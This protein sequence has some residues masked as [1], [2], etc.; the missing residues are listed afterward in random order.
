[1]WHPSFCAISLAARRGALLTVALL[2]LPLISSIRAAESGKPALVVAGANETEGL[3]VSTNATAF[4]RSIQIINTTK[5][6]VD[7]TVDVSDLI[8]PDSKQVLTSWKLDGKPGPSATTQVKGLGNAHLDI[9]TNLSGAGVYQSTISLTYNGN[10][11][12]GL[13]DP[14]GVDRNSRVRRFETG[15]FSTRRKASCQNKCRLPAA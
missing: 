13:N 11:Y 9:T 3:A 10:R 1:M 2:F 8:G 7:V 12:P 14:P 4:V 5:D 15:L 6:P